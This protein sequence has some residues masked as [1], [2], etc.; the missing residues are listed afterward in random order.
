MILRFG[1]VDY[2]ARVWVNGCLAMTHEGGHTPFWADITNLLDPS[3]KQKV[4]VRVEDD[5]RAVPNGPAHCLR[6]APAL[7]ADHDAERQIADR[8]DAAIAA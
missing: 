5:P 4:T 1:A 3:G 6:I 7:V 8:E 2:A